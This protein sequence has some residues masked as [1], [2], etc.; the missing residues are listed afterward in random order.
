MNTSDIDPNIWKRLLD[1]DDDPEQIVLAL[2]LKPN[3][4]Q[5]F[6]DQGGLSSMEKSSA[7][8]LLDAAL[9]VEGHLVQGPGEI[10]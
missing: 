1:A 2:G 4:I 3:E 5:V 6:L 8:R 9:K 10:S 7:A